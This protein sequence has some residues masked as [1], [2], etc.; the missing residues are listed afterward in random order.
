[1]STYI[2]LING[3]AENQCISPF[4]SR[5]YLLHIILWTHPFI[6]GP[7][8]KGAYNFLLVVP[9]T[10]NTVAKIVVGIVDT[11]VT[12]SVSQA[13]KGAIPIYIFPVDQEPGSLITILP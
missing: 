5:I 6:S 3:A 2:F 9:A 11:L 12:N 8:Q 7:L 13:H 1:M 4:L 10:A